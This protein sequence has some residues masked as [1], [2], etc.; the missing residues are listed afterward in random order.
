MVELFTGQSLMWYRNHRRPWADWQE[1]KKDFMRFFLHSRYF[2]KLDDQIR[3][4]CQQRGETF[5]AYALR[6]Q[7]LMGHMEYTMQQKINRIYRNSRR[8]Y[9]LFIG[10]IECL[11]IEKSSVVANV[12]IGRLL[13]KE[14]IETGVTRTI[15]KSSLQDVIPFVSKAPNRSRTIRMAD[16]TLRYSHRELVTMV[17]VR[18]TH[19][20]LPLIVLDDVVDNLTAELFIG[21]RA[22]QFGSPAQRPKDSWSGKPFDT[23]TNPA[24]GLI[25]VRGPALKLRG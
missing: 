20:Q 23:I 9:Q 3:Q 22:I 13:I 6:M 21:K 5:K 24:H 19:F 8:E 4:T 11:R 15:I 17:S 10:Q 1:F 25:R 2:E 14:V 7:D 18:G 12:I 16:G